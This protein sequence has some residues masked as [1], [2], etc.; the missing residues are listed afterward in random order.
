[1]AL[2]MDSIVAR[3][4]HRYLLIAADDADLEINNAPSLRALAAALGVTGVAVA[5]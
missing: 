3:A 2:P 5:L 1:M 4:L